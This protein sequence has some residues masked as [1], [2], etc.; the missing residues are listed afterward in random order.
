[1]KWKDTGDKLVPTWDVSPTNT[2]V[3]ILYKYDK[4]GKLTVVP[5]EFKYEIKYPEIEH[6]NSDWAFSHYMS[7]LYPFSDCDR[8]FGCIVKTVV[9]KEQFDLGVALKKAEQILAQNGVTLE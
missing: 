1:M 6:N 2:Y 3:A 5:D 7:N 4:K 9:S 8:M